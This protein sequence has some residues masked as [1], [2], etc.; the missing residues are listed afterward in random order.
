MSGFKFRLQKVLD[1]RVHRERESATRLGEAQ[2]RVR[3][4]EHA[5]ALLNAVRAST[6]EQLFRAHGDGGTVGQLQN[7]RFI[8]GQLDARI[9]DATA[10]RDIAE[11]QVQDRLREFTYALQQRRVL[12]HLKERQYEASRE[13]ATQWERKVMD[14]IAI[15]RHARPRPARETPEG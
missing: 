8:L 12:E 14:D 11:E 7:L 6:A 4:A 1:L 10:E 15:A 3:E 2:R 5:L 9:A 13:E